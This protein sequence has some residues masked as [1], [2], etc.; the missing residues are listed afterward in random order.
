L[1]HYRTKVVLETLNTSKVSRLAKVD[2][3]RYQSYFVPIIFAFDGNN[4]FIPIDDK[5]K[6]SKKF[7]LNKN[8]QKI[9]IIVVTLLT[10]VDGI[11]II[12]DHHKKRNF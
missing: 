1:F 3:E 9:P 2:P 6:K 5:I 8:I 10:V 7:T 12:L 4:I 11:K